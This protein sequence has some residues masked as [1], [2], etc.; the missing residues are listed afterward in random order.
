MDRIITIIT[1]EGV[2][3]E[4]GK[5]AGEVLRDVLLTISKGVDFAKCTSG[6]DAE[7]GQGVI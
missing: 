2:R 3:V 1:D 5:D 7:Q 4:T 6:S